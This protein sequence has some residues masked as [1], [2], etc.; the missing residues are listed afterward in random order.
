YIYDGDGTIDLTSVDFSDIIFLLWSAHEL[1]LS[2]L[3]NYIENKIV[4]QKDLVM[5][6]ISLVYQKGLSEFTKLTELCKDKNIF[7]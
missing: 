1:R 3:C 4:R 6:N 5:K 2:E 7:K